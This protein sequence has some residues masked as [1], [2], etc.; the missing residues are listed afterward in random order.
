[1]SRIKTVPAESKDAKYVTDARLLE[2]LN[3]I[4]EHLGLPLS[5][6]IS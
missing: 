5:D 4:E 2:A 3:R 1:M 6:N